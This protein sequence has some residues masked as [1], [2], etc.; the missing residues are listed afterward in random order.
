MLQPNYC[1][2][3]KAY[4]SSELNRL[5]YRHWANQIIEAM[6]PEGEADTVVEL[7]C[8]CGFTTGVFYDHY[9]PNL[10]CGVDIS[11]EMLGLAQL[12]Y[13]FSQMK[14]LNEGAEATSLSSGIADRV[15]SSF[16]FHWF[17]TEAA[18]LEINRLLKP[19]G[20]ALLVI[21][22]FSGTRAHTM[23][24]VLL[25]R[26]LIRALRKGQL[27]RKT[28][29]GLSVE[30]LRQPI[31]ASGLH[32]LDYQQGDL[33]ETFESAERLW[34]TLDSRGSLKAIFG[35]DRASLDLPIENTE[36]CD[37]SWRVLNLLL[38]KK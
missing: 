23:G 38:E 12:N 21:P 19:G 14:F 13:P 34:S 7:G 22:T 11:E 18:L 2:R 4:S 31:G 30:S 26:A 5:F 20:R 27:A 3:A 10:Y 15:V 28:S 1:I 25:R 24:N 33:I 16:A 35:L 8:G 36:R 9:R 37:F 17:N 29:V 6:E 32:L